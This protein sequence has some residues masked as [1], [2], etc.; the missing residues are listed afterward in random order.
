MM[1]PRWRTISIPG[2]RKTGVIELFGLT[3]RNGAPLVQSTFLVLC[4]LLMY[5]G[6]ACA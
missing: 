5:I 6:F 3:D 1:G 2:Q 4:C